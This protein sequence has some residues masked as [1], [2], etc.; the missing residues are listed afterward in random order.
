MVEVA[1]VAFKAAQDEVTDEELDELVK[2]YY[3]PVAKKEEEKT[4]VPLETAAEVQ[5]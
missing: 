3:R 2:S 4:D 5:E 1:V